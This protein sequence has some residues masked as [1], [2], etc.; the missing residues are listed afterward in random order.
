[1]TRSRILVVI[2]ALALSLSL[3]TIASTETASAA[4]GRPFDPGYIISDAVFYNATT[5]T[6]QEIQ[7]FLNQKVP[8]CQSGYTCLKSYKQATPN[9]A[10]DTFC[11]GYAGASSETAAQIIYKVAQSC[12]INPQ[13]ILVTLQKEQ[14]LVTHVWPSDWRYEKAM[15]YACS[16]SAPCDS[17]YGGFVYQVYYAARQFQRY[18]QQP[19]RY[20]Y[21]AGRV[22]TI[23]YNPNAA[24]GSSPVYIQ[25]QATAGLYNYTPYQPNAAALAAGTGTGDTCSSYGNRNFWHYFWLW[26]GDPTQSSS[27]IKATHDPKIYLTVENTRYHVPDWTLYT[28]LA[29]AL[30]AYTEV[31]PTY[32]QN[33][34]DGGKAGRLFSNPAGRIAL[35]S[36]GKLHWFPSCNDMTNFGYQYCGGPTSGVIVLTAGQYNA[37]ASGPNIYNTVNGPDGAVMSV[38]HG[39]IT[40]YLSAQARNEAGFTATAPTLVDDAMTRVTF[41]PPSL[42]ITALVAERGSSNT[43]LVKGGVKYPI[44]PAIAPPVDASGSLRTASLATL[45]SG[46]AISPVMASEDGRTVWLSKS[47]YREIPSDLAVSS[48]AP[49]VIPA[50]VLASWTNLG[51]IPVGS[52]I[53]SPEKSNL[54]WVTETGLRH[55]TTWATAIQLAGGTSPTITEVPQSFIDSYKT[56]GPI[57]PFG[58]LVRSESSTRQFYISSVST[59]HYVSSFD[60]TNAAGISG[61]TIVPDSHF[62]GY[63]E[64]VSNFGF[65][66]MCGSTAYAAAGGS[67]HAIPPELVSS[68]PAN[69]TPLD[70]YT[71]ATL[72]V[73]EPAGPFIHTPSGQ[74]FQLSDGQKHHITSWSLWL[75]ISNGR[76]WL[77]VSQPFAD[78][79]PTGDPVY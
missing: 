1:M 25:N 49:A 38:T 78:A 32:V 45:P 27:L 9:I 54:Y 75:Q 2:L 40:E 22:N 35:L 71:C 39:I 56:G 48:S 79:I 6:A 70:A 12:G 46:Q 53:K 63:S 69:L 60:L 31:S 36:D 43:Y 57:L 77:S 13:V 37:F 21:Q 10:A 29:R 8:T 26:F 41:G 5:M 11:K 59:R 72:K 33:Y 58:T 20:N 67:V 34:S 62:A 14:G 64:A 73:G 55:I 23:L 17:R 50:N 66:F 51:A 61:W 24:C 28:E 52:F 4:P 30:G 15:G 74:V 65:G 7:T 42:P 3:V 68:Y 18:A 47:G 19:T 44:D 76:S 16:D